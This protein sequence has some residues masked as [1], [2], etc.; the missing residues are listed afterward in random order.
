[1]LT[2]ADKGTLAQRVRRPEAIGARGLDSSQHV[3][4]SSGLQYTVYNNHILTASCAWFGSVRKSS[5]VIRAGC[6]AQLLKTPNK[7]GTSVFGGLY[8]SLF[9]ACTSCSLYEMMQQG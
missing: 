9:G 8:V 6:E 5:A 1:M 2:P 3:T 4:L 7:C